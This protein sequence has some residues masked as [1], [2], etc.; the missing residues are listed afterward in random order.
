MDKLYAIKIRQSDGTYGAA[1]PVSV[2]AENVDWSSTLS[3]VDILGQVDTSESIQD[4]INNLKNTR[5]T[6]ASVNALDQKVD[7]AVEYITHNSEIAEARVGADDTSYSSLKERLDGEYDKLEDGIEENKSLYQQYTE[8]TQ[9][10][11]SEIR[12][13]LSAE[14]NARTS[15]ISAEAEARQAADNTLQSN[16]NSEASTRATTDASLQSQINQL[17]APSG[18]APSAAEIENARIGSDSVTYSTLGDAIRTQNDKIKS[19][20]HD[21]A[22]SGCLFEDILN[23]Y[24]IETGYWDASGRHSSQQSASIPTIQTASDN[25]LIITDDQSTYRFSAFVYDAD[26]TTLLVNSWYNIEKTM[27]HKGTKFTVNLRYPDQRVLSTEA[28]KEIKS[29]I[30]IYKIISRP[31]AEYFIPASSHGGKVL[32]GSTGNWYANIVRWYADEDMVVG[33]E[34]YAAGACSVFAWKSDSDY[35]SFV[36]YSTQKDT[37]IK[38][39]MW[40]TIL[41]TSPNSIKRVPASQILLESTLSSLKGI[42]ASIANV[43]NRLIKLEQENALPS[44]YDTYIASKC[45]TINALVPTNGVQFAFITDPHINIGTPA[46]HSKALLNYISRHTLVDT[47]VCGGDLANGGTKN[48]APEFAQLIRDGYDYINPDNHWNVLSVAGNHDTGIEYNEDL[49]PTAKLIS[50][51]ILA[52]NT[53]PII[54]N[55]TNLTYDPSG[56]L[57]YFVDNDTEKVRYIVMSAGLKGYDSSADESYTDEYIWLCNALASTPSGYTVVV[58][59]HVIYIHT[60]DSAPNI[61]ILEL[62]TVCDQYN[63]RGKSAMYNS[64]PETV[65][66]FSNAGGTV[67][68]WVGGHLHAD[69]STT[70]TGG[71]PVIVTTTDNGSVDENSGAGREIG[72]VNEQAF[73]VITLNISTKTINATRI[74]GGSDRTFTY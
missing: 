52:R 22:E 63:S 59:N 21:F 14:T 37:F 58:F 33:L 8:T 42:P 23:S 28:L 36:S 51:K 17:V 57:N 10:L 18:E 6:Q 60:T 5:A 44:Y 1:I 24:T 46:L 61:F 15:A 20:L 2:L 35:I 13:D 69:K 66:D 29:H 48:G 50:D 47:V 16:I 4:Q 39:G 19:A 40:Y 7:N 62:L 27:V 68:C 25:L 34:S 56:P 11:I 31:D 55:L 71:I 54:K 49:T 41:T 26:G 30:H 53:P 72:T 73:D 3:L 64:R 65:F 32:F 9:T 38:K 74:G 12:G 43:R 67:A 70:S 45:D